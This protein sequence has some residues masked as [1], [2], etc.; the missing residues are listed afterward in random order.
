[1][2]RYIVNEQEFDTQQ[3][4]TQAVLAA[5][6]S[7]GQRPL[8]QCS[9]PSG[10][11]MY[12]AYVGNEF[13]VKRMPNTGALHAPHC[14]SYEPPAELSG[15]GEIMGSA[16]TEDIEQGT[17]SLK[18]AF[19]M[20]R[21]AGRARATGAGTESDSVK[22]DA[23][24]LTLRGMLH[25]LWDEAGFNRWTPGMEDKRSW[26]VI[27]RY[28]HKAADGKI[29][30]GEALGE[31]LFIPE[32]L[33]VEHKDDIARRRTAR[34]AGLANTA[35]GS[36]RLMVMIAE[37]KEMETAR[38]GEK[39]IIKHL[40]DY[41]ILVAEELFKRMKKRFENE[42]AIWEA[43]DDTHLVVIGTI[44]MMPGNFP[45]FEEMA[46]MTVTSEWIPFESVYDK[47]LIEQLTRARR[48]FV[49]G[50]RYNMASQRPMA[51]CVASDTQ[52]KPTAMYIVPTQPTQAYRAS[53][54]ELVQRTQLMSWF[55]DTATDWTPPLP[56]IEGFET[57]AIP[58]PPD[59]EPLEEGDE[60][61]VQAEPLTQES[62]E[63]ESAAPPEETQ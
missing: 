41:P 29:A 39:L 25:F 30:N 42:I 8:C 5:A 9:R 11:E 13:I 51:S 31:I 62:G 17:T 37:I 32:P 52:P 57:M 50:L 48:S 46:L 34:L 20:S 59:D 16:I 45:E 58:E 23:K 56:R 12:I 7:H 15:L 49:K 35:N 19:S 63:G 28:L 1:M 40:P 4:E 61:E 33:I 38:Y 53:L 3:P 6:H 22:S 60:I 14:E 2:T 43:T 36:R 21:S 18:L 24:K 47:L 26:N 10:T 54:A 27:R 44:G 55:W